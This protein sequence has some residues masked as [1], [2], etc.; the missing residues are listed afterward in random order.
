VSV[1][2]TPPRARTA[3]QCVLCAPQAVPGE[4]PGEPGRTREAKQGGGGESPAVRV[5]TALC[6]DSHAPSPAAPSAPLRSHQRVRDT[7]QVGQGRERRVH[8]GPNGKKVRDTGG[9]CSSSS[10]LPP[11]KLRSMQATCRPRAGPAA[12]PGQQHAR[13]HVSRAEP[14]HRLCRRALLALLPPLLAGAS[15]AVEEA[16]LGALAPAWAPVAVSVSLSPGV[17]VPAAGAALYVTLRPP[18]R[19]PPIAARRVPWPLAFPLRLELTAEDGLPDA[20]PVEAWREL[21]VSARLDTDG[22]AATR[23]PTDLVGRGAARRG[24]SED[25]W[26][27]AQVTLVGRGFAGRL[28]T[29]R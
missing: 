16:P 2:A 23:D 20:P 18:G 6:P 7:Q 9:S 29:Q 5:E 21:M 1:S 24:A 28:A 22:V 26:E 10:S 14:Q 11:L 13:A 17:E 12:P 19:G 27:E 15:Q 8:D 4:G 25:S 3:C